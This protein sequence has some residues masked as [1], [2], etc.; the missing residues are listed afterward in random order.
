MLLLAPSGSKS[1]QFS[2][3]SVFSSGSVE[4]DCKLTTVPSVGD[5][6][7]VRDWNNTWYQ[8]GI[9]SCDIHR[10]VQTYFFYENP[11]LRSCSC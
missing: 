1:F 6:V 3:Q 10:E 2:D 7:D 11:Y 8:V 9:L 5:L 4:S